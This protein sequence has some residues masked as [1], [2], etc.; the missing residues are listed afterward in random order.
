MSTKLPR[1]RPPTTGTTPGKV[2][3]AKS[4]ANLERAGGHRL[5]INLGPE[6][7]LHLASVMVAENFDTQR[8][9]VEHVLKAYVE[10]HL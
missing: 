9:A 8:A 10:D 2:R 7:A 3:S 5:S 6:A 4:R 1:G